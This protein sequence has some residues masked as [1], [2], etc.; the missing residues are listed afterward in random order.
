MISIVIPT[1]NN[2]DRVIQRVKRKRSLS[3]VEAVLL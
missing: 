1:K 2:G 3:G